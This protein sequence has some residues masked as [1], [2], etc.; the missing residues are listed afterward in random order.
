M[1]FAQHAKA[2]A[3]QH[4]EQSRRKLTEQI[5]ERQLLEATVRNS[6]RQI[7]EDDKL[8]LPVNVKPA[9][10]NFATDNSPSSYQSISDTA[11]TAS[12]PIQIGIL[13]PEPRIG[14]LTSENLH[15]M[16]GGRATPRILSPRGPG[17]DNR[18]DI[19]SPCKKSSF[20]E[21]DVENVIGGE[22]VPDIAP[23]WTCA[24]VLYSTIAVIP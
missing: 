4:V 8:A 19:M 5:S 16:N 21:G 11:S 10:S 13:S 9:P 22:I 7:V 2:F 23:A 12:E 18:E 1:I 3:A 6:L 17:M 15:E 20:C 24:R 14:L